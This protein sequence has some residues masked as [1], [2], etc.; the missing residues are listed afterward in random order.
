[1][2]T[3]LA[4]AGDRDGPAEDQNRYERMDEAFHRR[5]RDGFLAIARSEPE[6]CVIIDAGMDMAAVHAEIRN[7]V[8][9]RLGVTF[10]AVQ[11]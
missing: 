1:M 10:K 8:A 3:G 7:A 5:L 11:E 2:E 6:R 4:R 9:E